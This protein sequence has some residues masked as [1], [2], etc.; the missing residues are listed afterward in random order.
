MHGHTVRLHVARDAHVLVGRI[1]GE[2]WRVGRAPALD[3]IVARGAVDFVC[4]VTLDAHRAARA[5]AQI[6]EPRG[7]RVR[8]DAILAGQFSDLSPARRES[9]LDGG[10]QTLRRAGKNEF[11][12]RRQLAT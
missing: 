12:P 4:E 1:R 2:V 8:L 11:T 10:A 6:I 5:D 7:E 3:E 9:G